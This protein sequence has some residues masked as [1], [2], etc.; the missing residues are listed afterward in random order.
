M[1]DPAVVVRVQRGEVATRRVDPDVGRHRDGLSVHEHV[2]V[3][4]DVKDRSL[5][6]HDGETDGL[7]PGPQ[8][9]GGGP[10]RLGAGLEA[11]QRPRGQARR[12]RGEGR[13]RGRP[14]GL[15]PF[16]QVVAADHEDPRHQ[17]QEGGA[18]PPLAA[19]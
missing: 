15:V 19:Q 4:V 13:R 6:G 10:P 11:R 1:D 8:V 5:A 2:E 17:D 3:G 16:P 7:E 9:G 18:G 14:P 12:R